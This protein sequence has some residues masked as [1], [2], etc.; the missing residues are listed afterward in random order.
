MKGK[1]EAGILEP[2]P[3][4]GKISERKKLAI[5]LILAGGVNFTLGRGDE[6][7]RETKKKKKG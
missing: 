4:K 6:Q 3:C 2:R 7:K 5:L 1:R